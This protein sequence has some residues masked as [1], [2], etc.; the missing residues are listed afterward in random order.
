MSLPRACLLSGPGCSDGGVAAPGSSRC[1]KHG[2]RAWPRKDPSRQA[3]YRGNWED[4]RKIV[5]ARDRPV[6][7]DFPAARSR[8]PWATMS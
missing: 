7:G 8:A 4:L 5:L 1:R 3:A 6:T 2:G